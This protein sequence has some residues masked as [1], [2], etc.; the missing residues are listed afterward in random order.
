[1][2]SS[3]LTLMTPFLRTYHLRSESDSKARRGIPPWSDRLSRPSFSDLFGRRTRS[4]SNSAGSA[5][6]SF[7]EAP[8]QG[9]R[10]LVGTPGEV[11]AGNP[12][13]YYT[14]SI[15]DERKHPYAGLYRQDCCRLAAFLSK[16]R[17][18]GSATPELAAVAGS[19][20]QPNMCFWT[21]PALLGHGEVWV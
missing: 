10:C 11:T 14:V 19:G 17:V 2:P 18:P 6:T 7:T 9:L 13:K 5:G 8:R 20:R 16:W 4:R 15:E 21:A 3:S 1:M 12:T